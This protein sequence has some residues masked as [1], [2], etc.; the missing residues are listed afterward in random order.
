M[1]AYTYPLFLVTHSLIH[2]LTQAIMHN[3]VTLEPQDTSPASMKASDDSIADRGDAFHVLTEETTTGRGIENSGPCAISES[4][5]ENGTKYVIRCRPSLSGRPITRT[6]VPN[7]LNILPFYYEQAN[8]AK[9]RKGGVPDSSDLYRGSDRIHTR[10]RDAVVNLKSFQ[11]L[12]YQSP[13]D[14]VNQN[15]CEGYF[16]TDWLLHM[17]QRCRPMEQIAVRA[18]QPR[19]V[20]H[21]HCV[22]P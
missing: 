17:R 20:S 21:L 19:V 12:C 1:Y 2:K 7:G 15:P 11:R 3:Y 10:F 6:Q 13:F 16:M 5:N 18:T 9:Y 4:C 22:P 14:G 8:W